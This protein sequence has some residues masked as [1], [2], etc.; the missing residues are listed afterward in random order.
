MARFSVIVPVYNKKEYLEECIGSVLGQSFT[1]FELIIVDDGS[2]D[3]SDEVCSE[4]EENDR[5]VKVIVQENR[6][7]AVARQHGVEAAK[8][9]FCLFLDGDDYW[10]GDLLDSVN[11][12]IEAGGA[13]LVIFNY[14]RVGDGTPKEAEHLFEDGE[15]FEE[16]GKRRLF[17]IIIDGWQL[18]SL[19]T[20]AYKRT[21]FAN[22]FNPDDR[23][24]RTSEDLLLNLPLI[25]NAKKTVYLRKT[26][27]NRRYVPTSIVN[28]FYDGYLDDVT[29][30]RERVWEYIELM[31]MDTHDNLCRLYQS[32][33]DT[34][35][36]YIRSVSVS[37]IEYAEKCE[38]FD[39]IAKNT[40][41]KEAEIYT[42]PE[43][44]QKDRA[45]R[46]KL[47]LGGNRRVLIAYDKGLEAAKSVHK[48]R[49]KK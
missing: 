4:F 33:I 15:S 18:N 36:K 28:S 35:M 23:R 5:R 32:Y 11:T 10:D 14:R 46:L 22:A 8:G 30:V 25:Y 13:D 41:F 48:H 45:L 6:G 49:K 9:E 2:T 38:I 16:N 29:Y 47:F 40:F 7:Q 31:K 44:L 1:D 42:D 19:C 39:R 24:L 26:L 12:V 37:G 3:G 21:L 43:N 27:Y 34:A 17:S 20:K